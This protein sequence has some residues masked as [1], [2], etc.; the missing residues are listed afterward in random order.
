MAN[1]EH[2]L[3]YLTP[4]M[5][6]GEGGVFSATYEERFQ[7]TALMHRLK[8]E[9]GVPSIHA[10]RE[11]LADI[12]FLEDGTAQIPEELAQTA[13]QVEKR[14][15]ES[16]GLPHSKVE[17]E[18]AFATADADI[19]LFTQGT[20][21]RV[22]QIQS[23]NEVASQK[24]FLIL[25]AYALNN[26][27]PRV[28]VE[29]ARKLY[30]ADMALADEKVRKDDKPRIDYFYHLMD[31]YMF[32]DPRKPKN[33]VPTNLTYTHVISYHMGTD[34]RCGFLRKLTPGE[35]IDES[36]LHP[37]MRIHT[38]PMRTWYDSKGEP[39]HVLFEPRIKDK[40]K[41]NVKELRNDTANPQTLDDNLGGKF[42]FE[43]LEEADLFLQTLMSKPIPISPMVRGV[44]YTISD[45]GDLVEREFV[46]R[47]T[48]SAKNFEI[49]KYHVIISGVWYEIQVNTT[50]T[51]IDQKLRDGVCWQDYEV[52]RMTISDKKDGISVSELLFPERIFGVHLPD[53]AEATIK[54]NQVA[55][56]HEPP[57]IPPELRRHGRITRVMNS[58]EL[59]SAID[60]LAVQILAS[61]T[62]RS[63]HTKASNNTREQGN[64][65]DINSN[66][67]IVIAEN[68]S[69]R[70]EPSA[71][72]LSRK[73]GLPEGHVLSAEEIKK[74]P[75]DSKIIIFDDVYRHAKHIHRVK[76]DLL[77]K[78]HTRSSIITAVLVA[79][80]TRL[81]QHN[82]FFAETISPKTRIVF[83]L[84]N[85]RKIYNETSVFIC[86]RN[87][88]GSTEILVEL[89]PNGKIKFPGGGKQDNELPIQTL[90]REIEEEL[91]RKVRRKYIKQTFQRPFMSPF[92]PHDDLTKPY[93]P[94]LL[95][96][97]FRVAPEAFKGNL[98]AGFGWVKIHS[99]EGTLR[100]RGQK[101]LW[102]ELIRKKVISFNGKKHHKS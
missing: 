46:G 74:L 40:A 11:S 59:R 98:P 10:L 26:P 5:H 14:W 78:G 8:G 33:H 71:G 85:E 81:A 27:D 101:L 87:T 18:N 44:N 34:F 22:Q 17:V 91:G 2:N 55:R 48:A 42:T 63:P 61:E 73:L 102:R 13:E 7:L 12:V 93:V 64:I 60:S 4:I 15:V 94:Y 43:T 80:K 100:W 1:L 82:F 96:S 67:Y 92:E 99:V 66:T 36:M 88:N 97:V 90:L 24:N 16:H 39:H 25:L 72:L 35:Q 70:L 28:R 29:S 19:A 58:S 9:F 83:P 37:N 79:D 75:S 84:E 45:R 20:F 50:R 38:M 52:K 47:H 32:T 51:W 53:L 89:L 54:S 3:L 77:H 21:A 65:Q 41:F 57:I 62:K 6:P 95:H 76:S 68:P 49:I 56:R 69:T 23:I 30:L 31:T 86:T